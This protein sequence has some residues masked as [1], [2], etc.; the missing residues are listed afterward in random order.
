MKKIIIT[1]FVFGLFV[2]LYPIHSAFAQM[3][4]PFGGLAT[5][6]IPCT[7]DG[8]FMITIPNA[9]NLLV[10]ENFI[11]YPSFSLLYANFLYMRPGV[12]MLGTAQWAMMPCMQNA[13]A[14]CAPAGFGY[15][16]VM[17]GTSL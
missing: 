16:M 14:G 9:A 5:V 10:P 7:C 13:G 8:S 3:V 11:Y 4:K 17:L 15:P 12:Q 6:V 2:G 1:I